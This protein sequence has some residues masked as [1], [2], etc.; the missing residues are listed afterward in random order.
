MTVLNAKSP[1]DL[2]EAIGP[3]LEDFVDEFVVAGAKHSDVLNAIASQLDVLREAYDRDPDPAADPAAADEI[4][5][6]A[7]DW[8]AGDVERPE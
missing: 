5:E 4:E 1:Q 7:N 3:R 6:P 8:P 2:N